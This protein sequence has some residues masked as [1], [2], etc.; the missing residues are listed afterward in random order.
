MRR[1]LV[2]PGL[3]LVFVVSQAVRD[4]YFAAA[5]QGIDF[6]LVIVL[7]FTISAVGFGAVTLIREPGA[8]AKMRREPA[9]LVW[10]NVTTAIAWISYFFSLKYLQPSIAN[11][12]HSGTGPLTVI[13]LA[14][15]AIHIA[16]PSPIRSAEYVCHAGLAAS[17]AFLWWIALAGHSGLKLDNP[18]FG[19]AVLAL[20]IVSGAAITI[21]LLYCKRLNERGIGSDAVTAGRYPLIIL[22]ALAVVVLGDRPTGIGDTRE[23]ITLSIVTSVL[24]V[25]PLY[26]LQM[27]IAR[28]SPLTTH[29]MRSLGPVLVFAAE[30]VDGRIAYSGLT[31]FGIGLYSFFAVAGN[32]AHGWK[33][34]HAAF[35][36]T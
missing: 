26:A 20:P 22:I 12:L 6:F 10:M 18:S 4:V 31:M 28:T 9:A 17:L 14:S 29:V 34:E 2:G 8:F 1:E 27:G 33:G 3:V 30:L 5:F 24:I 13:A 23:F 21:S 36:R 35:A 19:L 7:A 11:T 25:L 16:R 15:F 32:L